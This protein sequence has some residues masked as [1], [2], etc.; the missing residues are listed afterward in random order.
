MLFNSSSTGYSYREIMLGF[1]II[2]GFKSYLSGCLLTQESMVIWSFLTLDFD[3]FRPITCVVCT[4]EY[5]WK[6]MG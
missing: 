3:L 5:A 4:W 6:V 1:L 2:T